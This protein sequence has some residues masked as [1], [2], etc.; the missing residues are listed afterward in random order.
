MKLITLTRSL[1]EMKYVCTLIH[2]ALSNTDYNKK[3]QPDL[4]LGTVSSE[5]TLFT[6]SM[7]DQ[8]NVKT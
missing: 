2:T 1:L 7:P 3:E 8:C 5:Y 6:S 4:V